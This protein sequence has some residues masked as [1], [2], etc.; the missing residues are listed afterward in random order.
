MFSHVFEL[1]CFTALSSSNDSREEFNLSRY[2]ARQL[3]HRTTEL[4]SRERDPCGRL[5]YGQAVQRPQNKATHS[6]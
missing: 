2:Q 1:T 5:W 4:E 3:P 6:V